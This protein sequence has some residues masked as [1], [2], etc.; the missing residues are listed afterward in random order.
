VHPDDTYA[1]EHENAELG[2]TECWYIIDC[3]EN[4]EMIFGHMAQTKEEFVSMIEK[5]ECN[6]LLRRILVKPGD[7]FYVPSGRSTLYVKVHLC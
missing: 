3:D 5:G 6:D 1:N 4:A 7:F 2:K